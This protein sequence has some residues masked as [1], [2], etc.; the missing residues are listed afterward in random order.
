MARGCDCLAIYL[1]LNICMIRL[2]EQRWY[3]LFFGCV[4]SVPDVMDKTVVACLWRDPFLFG[5][6]CLQATVILLWCTADNNGCGVGGEY[7][8]A[9]TFLLRY[10]HSVWYGTVLAVL[11][12]KHCGMYDILPWLDIFDRTDGNGRG[13]TPAVMEGWRQ[14]ADWPDETIC[15]WRY[16][17]YRMETWRRLVWWRH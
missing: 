9:V 11:E 12:A 13:V 3:S 7:Y 15:W 4:F 10:M 5:V 8:D 1:I 14:P 16:K 17:P 6:W 2:F